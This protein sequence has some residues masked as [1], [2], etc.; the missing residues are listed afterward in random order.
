MAA[1]S[2]PSLLKYPRFAPLSG[3]Y[4][5]L[6]NL[7]FFVLCERIAQLEDVVRRNQYALEKAAEEQQVLAMLYSFRESIDN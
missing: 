6:K 5:I 3:F 7:I 2:H 4:V 1:T